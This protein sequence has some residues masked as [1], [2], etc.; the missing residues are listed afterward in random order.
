MI[1][2]EQPPFVPPTHQ[3]IYERDRTA[4]RSCQTRACRGTLFSPA[5][6][7]VARG[8]RSGS[9][10]GIHTPRPVVMDCALSAC[11]QAPNDRTRS[12]LN[13]LVGLRRSLARQ[14]IVIGTRDRPDQSTIPEHEIEIE[15][16]ERVQAVTP[17][18][19]AF[20]MRMPLR[21]ALQGT[22]R[23]P[24]ALIFKRI[25]AF[26]PPANRYLVALL[27]VAL[28]RHQAIPSVDNSAPSVQPEALGDGGP[29]SPATFPKFNVAQIARELPARLGRGRSERP[30]RRH[31]GP[32]GLDYR[33][34]DRHGHASAR[35][36]AAQSTA[37]SA[38]IVVAE[39]D[40]H[41]NV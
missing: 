29:G 38:R 10:P 36:A 37:P 3:N 33:V 41:R 26:G 9:E 34:K 39:P 19:L 17:S 25:G 14:F 24:S 8:S 28:P 11:G 13:M 4:P 5:D 16:S 12:F 27:P 6:A 40:C 22:V 1:Q 35:R 21:Q 7:P 32:C 23:R 31:I 15:P 30:L 18:P 20:P 2:T